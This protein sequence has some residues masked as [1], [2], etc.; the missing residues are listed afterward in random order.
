MKYRVEPNY[1]HSAYTRLEVGPLHSHSPI[2]REL[3]GMYLDTPQCV[4]LHFA[5]RYESGQADQLNATPVGNKAG[6]LTSVDVYQSFQ[7]I[8][9]TSSSPMMQPIKQGKKTW[10]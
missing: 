5:S 10:P 6:I 4:G 1:H 2:T 7:A 9:R 8:H 3:A